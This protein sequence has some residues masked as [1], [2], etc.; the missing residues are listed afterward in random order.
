MLH[1]VLY[2]VSFP[3]ENSKVDIAKA[4]VFPPLQVFLSLPLP[5]LGG[6]LLRV[7]SSFVSQE[8]S[9]SVAC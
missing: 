6:Q 5:F 4:N 2:P 1:T 9:D 8:E 7:I 3:A